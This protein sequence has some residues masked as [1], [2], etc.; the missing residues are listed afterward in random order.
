MRFVKNFT[1][2]D[3]HAKN[4]TPLFS[5]NFN[6]FGDKNTKKMSENGDINTASK[7]FTLPPAVTALTNLT[8]EH[9]CYY[10]SSAEMLTLSV[11]FF[12]SGIWGKLG[13]GVQG[14]CLKSCAKFPPN[15]TMCSRD[16]IGPRPY[17]VWPNREKP[18][19]S[20][21]L[22]VVNAFLSTNISHSLALESSRAKVMFLF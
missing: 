22:S 5:P 4:F 12:R 2:L 16:A 8:S 11:D 9:T 17:K 18:L 14:I 21:Q 19:T 1:P 15:R 6:S 3:L 7:N 13:T 20:C 10:S